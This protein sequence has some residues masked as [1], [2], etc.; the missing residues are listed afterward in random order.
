[1]RFQNLES[2]C[3]QS[4]PYFFAVEEEKIQ[5]NGFTPK[6]FQ[7]SIR[8]T[9]V[10]GDEKESAGNQR[11]QPVLEHWALLIAWNVDYRVEGNNATSSTVPLQCEHR[12]PGKRYIGIE[13]T[14]FLDHSHR[15][16]DPGDRNSPF[17][18]KA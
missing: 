3:L 11:I 5:R 13:S 14:R 18:K 10:E 2:A 6:F 1:M 17:G 12:F 16:I 9:D 8:L 15:E 4:L 7:V